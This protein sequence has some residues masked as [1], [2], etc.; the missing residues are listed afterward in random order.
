MPPELPATAGDARWQ[1]SDCDLVA[2]V[3]DDIAR[4]GLPAA[5]PEGF[6]VRRLPHVYPVYDLGYAASLRAVESWLA[7]SPRLLTLGRHARFA[8]DNS[9]HGIAMGWAAGDA[10]GSADRFDETRWS[11]AVAAA[12]LHVVED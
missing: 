11:A 3:V 6:V 4:A 8:Y 2:T 1:G 12:R 5:R 9:H 7:S 10:L